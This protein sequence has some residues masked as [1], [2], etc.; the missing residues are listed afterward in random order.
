[1]LAQTGNPHTRIAI[2]T[3]TATTTRAKGRAKARTNT[4]TITRTQGATDTDMS[5]Q[6]AA[7]MSTQMNG[8]TTGST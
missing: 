5:T 4:G 1:M 3:V 6:I 2:H 7:I 8:R